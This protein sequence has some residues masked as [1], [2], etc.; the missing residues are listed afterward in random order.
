MPRVQSRAAFASAVGTSVAM[1]SK[2]VPASL[3]EGV[4]ESDEE[5]EDM[6]FRVN[7]KRDEAAM[8]AATKNRGWAGVVEANR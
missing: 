6:A 7:V 8:K 2:H 4:T 1:S 5:A 3:F